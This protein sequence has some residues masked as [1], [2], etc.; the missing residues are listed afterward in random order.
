[1]IQIENDM[2]YHVYNRGFLK[3]PIFKNNKDCR[4]FIALINKYQKKYKIQ[5]ESR[6]MMENH[7]HFLMIQKD[8]E[9]IKKF[10]QYLQMAYALYFNI[11]YHREGPLFESRFKAKP[12][13]EESYYIEIRR[14]IANNP[15]E[16]VLEITTKGNSLINSSSQT[17]NSGA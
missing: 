1:M 15:L 7:M 16:K 5:I 12:V 13:T 10:M 4:R 14:Y 9:S 2:Y 11:K 3:Q 8:E 17:L 6:A